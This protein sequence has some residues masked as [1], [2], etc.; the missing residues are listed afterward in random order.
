VSHPDAIVV[1]AGVIGAA[2]A[3]WLSL[4]GLSV[5][6]YD[7]AFPGAGAT[8]GGMGHIV[9]MDDSPAQLALTAYSRTLLA[10]LQLPRSCEMDACGTLWLAASDDELALLHE[11]RALYERA[12]VVTELF[13]ARDVA[14]AEPELRSGVAGALRVP[15]DAVLYPPALAQWLLDEATARGARFIR[16][17]V[18]A[19]AQ[20][21][22]TCDGEV[23]R[24]GF[25]VNAAGAR[26]P[27]L[28]PSLPIVPRRGHLVITDR[29]PGFCR[30]Q[31]VEL[32]YLRSAHTLDGASVAFNVQ[33][34]TTGQLLIGSSRELAGWDATVN[35]DIVQQ[36]MQRAVSWLPRIGALRAIRTWTAFRPATPDKLPFIGA[37]PARSDVFIAAGHEG[38]GITTAL[39]T[40][41]IIA[42]AAARRSSAIDA[43]PFS[44]ARIAA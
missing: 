41:R 17:R 23:H 9:V 13:D 33:P 29:Y 16:A 2:V 21:G 28:T 22:V 36:M 38:L 3:Y 18:D 10:D 1:G 37:L 8:S 4:D 42:D 12:G 26:A 14:A 15:G 19:I 44:P 40:G 6:V 5:H 43:A 35:R 34:R 25:V 20:H 31:L 27:A 7:E 32:G 39:A 11:K 30:H 24:A